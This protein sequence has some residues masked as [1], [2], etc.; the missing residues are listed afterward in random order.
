[1]VGGDPKLQNDAGNGRL[2]NRED[3]LFHLLAF[4]PDPLH[5]LVTTKMVVSAGLMIGIVIV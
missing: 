3:L 4:A 2:G 1:V 5:P